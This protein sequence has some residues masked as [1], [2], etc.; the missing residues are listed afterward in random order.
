MHKEIHGLAT[1]ESMW[2]NDIIIAIKNTEAFILD[3]VYRCGPCG[4]MRACHA[5]DPC[6]IPG[7]DKFLGEVF[8]VFFLPCKKNVGK[9]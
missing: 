4:N 6:S 3:P 5:A 1:Q 2:R 7:R 9:L 8:S